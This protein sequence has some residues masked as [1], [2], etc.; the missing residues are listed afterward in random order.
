VAACFA[1]AAF[2]AGFEYDHAA[3]GEAAAK[4]RLGPASISRAIPALRIRGRRSHRRPALH[5]RPML[6]LRPAKLLDTISSP[7][8]LSSAW[9]ARWQR[10]ISTANSPRLILPGGTSGAW[11]P[12]HELARHRDR[13][14]WLFG[15]PVAAL[16]QR[17]LRSG[18]RRLAAPG[19]GPDRLIHARHHDGRPGP[20]A[21]GSNTSSRRNGRWASKYL[22]TDLGNA[23]EQPAGYARLR[24][25]GNVLDRGSRAQSLLGRPQLQKRAGSKNDG[26]S[27][28]D[29]SSVRG[30][31][32]CSHLSTKP[33]I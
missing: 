9:R 24:L 3:A 21:S 1:Q 11:T 31:P 8:T 5:R 2:R 6:L 16:C 33:T 10:P 20:R 28:L 18:R 12:E 32:A 17:R 25:A 29:W 27:G 19:R 30:W 7:V 26:F 4:A 14:A 22:Y 13:P 23:P 15:G